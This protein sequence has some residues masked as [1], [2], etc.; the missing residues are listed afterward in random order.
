MTDQ[1][2]RQLKRRASTGD[3]QAAV[4]L[5]RERVRAKELSQTR[6]RLAAYAG[7]KAARELETDESLQVVLFR[8]V[9]TDKPW[10]MTSDVWCLSD[11]LMGLPS[12]DLDVGVLREDLSWPGKRKPWPPG[13]WLMLRCSIVAGRAAFDSILIK[14]SPRNPAWLPAVYTTLDAAWKHLLTGTIETREAWEHARSACPS[15]PW[16]CHPNDRAE[17]GRVLAAAKE[18]RDCKVCNGSGQIYEDNSRMDC[19]HCSG[20]DG[21]VKAHN[22]LRAD[23]VEWTLA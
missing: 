16:L 5:L 15:L 8:I 2:L 11:W 22:I 7:D 6:L 23:L 13:D 12:I 19:P 1:R 21:E 10:W 14:T 18:L 3:P 4:N 17:M 20:V 9:A